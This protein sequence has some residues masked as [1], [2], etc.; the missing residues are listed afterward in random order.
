MN[1]EPIF[2]VREVNNKMGESRIPVIVGVGQFTNKPSEIEHAIE[3]FEMIKVCIARA[4][5]DTNAKPFLHMADS[6]RVVGIFSWHYADIPSMIAEHVGARPREQIY[7][8]TGGNNPQFMINE[9]AREIAEGRSGISL[10]C[11]GEALHSRY[12]SRKL[13]K[14]LPWPQYSGV[15]QIYGE[16]TGGSNEIELQHGLRLPIHAFPLFENALR[17]EEDG[18]SIEENV[19]QTA[20]MCSAFANVARSNPH[21]WFRDGKSVGQIKT[22]TPSN[23]MVCFPYPK[24]MNSIWNVDMASAIII[25]SAATARKLGI[26]EEKWVFI[27]GAGDCTDAWYPTEKLNY[28]S[29]PGI[30]LAADYALI[31]AGVA[32]DDVEV[33][34]L[35][36][37]FPC[38][39]KM[40]KKMM[41]IK[42]TDWGALTVTGGLP[43]FGGP[44]NNYSSH[45][46]CS[47]VERLRKEPG[48]FGL[49]YATGW[50]F[51][52]HAVGIY[53]ARPKETEFGT[54]NCEQIRR[55]I[56]NLPYP[57]FIL[58][59]E[60]EATLETFTVVHN[61]DGQPDYAIIIGRQND[62]RRFIANT[63]RDPSLF[64]FLTTRDVIGLKGKV[65]YSP[66]LEINIFAP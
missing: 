27:H 39:P 15:P 29:I 50:Y 13:G 38:V 63:E 1:Y 64:Q 26:P 19:E 42:T 57:P 36:S 32:I 51:A 11:G 9:I 60:G 35:Y 10:L 48:K 58:K 44:G 37:C 52:K 20:R 5:E 61:H 62:G 45:A 43:Y 25:T 40:A 34:D 28:H 49:T 59:A 6:I 30:R 22:I 54:V 56:A 14:P 47:L 21:A 41:G 2:P 31:Q 8:N 4:T 55:E 24:Y 66:D 7:T 46:V 65:K 33:F 23:R 12:L 17:E 18:L 16:E 3:P 53:S